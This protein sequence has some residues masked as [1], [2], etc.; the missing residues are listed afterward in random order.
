MIGYNYHSFT[1]LKGFQVWSIVN[2]K[3]NDQAKEEAVRRLLLRMFC[4][5]EELRH[6]RI[7]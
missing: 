7:L 5:N 1:K 6:I 3:V 2:Q 4:N